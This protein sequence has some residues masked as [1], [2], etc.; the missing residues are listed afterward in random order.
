MYYLKKLIPIFIFLFVFMPQANAQRRADIG[1]S[2]ST[3]EKSKYNL[4]YRQ[5]LGEKYRVKLAVNYG[6]RAG[7]Y[8][9]VPSWAVAVSDSLI[10]T[11]TGRVYSKQY[12]FR[13]GVDRQLKQSAFSIGVDAGLALLRISFS[14]QLNARILNE[15]GQWVNATFIKEGEEIIGKDTPI[16]QTYIVGDNQFMYAVSNNLVPSFRASLNWD[17]KLGRF[18]T[19]KANVTAGLYFIN[20]RNTTIFSNYEDDFSDPSF[21]YS[22][23]KV[24]GS[25][26]VAYD[27]G[28]WK[29]WRAEKAAV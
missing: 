1:F 18:L 25:V 7:N 13:L 16:K 26:G 2:I 15:N 29:N 3:L 28:S 6:N 21:S 17:K 24:S 8:L 11:R 9:A 20:H 10:I 23:I 4:E 19:V 12:G 27:F 22:I 5:P 14:S